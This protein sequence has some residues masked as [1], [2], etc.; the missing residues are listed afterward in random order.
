VGRSSS[1]QNQQ[2]ADPFR[3]RR[4]PL[5]WMDE[6]LLLQSLSHEAELGL[7]HAQPR[8]LTPFATVAQAL[9]HTQTEDRPMPTSQDAARE[10]LVSGL[11][12]IHAIQRQ[13]KA[14]MKQVI[15][16]LDHYPDAKQRLIAHLTDKENEMKRAEQILQAMGKDVSGLKDS[17]FAAMGGMT[18]MMTGAASDDVLLSSMLTYG[19]ANY[20]IALYQSLLVLAEQAGQANATPLLQES[21]K[22]EQAMAQWLGDNLEPTVLR[23]LELKG[24][25]QNAAH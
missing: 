10:L 11:E 19:L 8:N 7:T 25:G 23:Y 17:T 14:M 16:R 15:D 13:A 6:S 24:Q 1:G 3:Q 21:L 9:S 5:G 22:E 18:A 20:E 4:D 2:G 12:N